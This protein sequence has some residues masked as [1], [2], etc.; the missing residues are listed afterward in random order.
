MFNPLFCSLKDPSPLQLKT[1]N[2][3]FK[4]YSSDF[5]S[6]Q[7]HPKFGHIFEEGAVRGTATPMAPEMQLGH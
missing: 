1:R 5:K 7:A 2:A 6:P 4:S 3:P